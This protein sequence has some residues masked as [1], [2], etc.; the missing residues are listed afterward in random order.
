MRAFFFGPLA[1]H[2]SF[3]WHPP[4]PQFKLTSKVDIG[5]FSMQNDASSQ[6]VARGRF[7]MNAPFFC[8]SRSLYI[9]LIPAGL[10]S[11]LAFSASAQEIPSTQPFARLE[12]G[13]HTARVPRIAVDPKGR[14][15]VSASYDK[16]ARVWDLA[17][18]NLLRILRPP[19]GED[20]EG[21]LYT[22]AL[23]PDGATVAVGGF[24]SK[25]GSQT[26]PVYLFDRE[27]GR[28]T[29]RISGLPGR[30]ID[31]AFSRDG[32]F[33]AAVQKGANGI[34][35]FRV[36]DRTEVWRDSKYGDDSYSVEFDRRGRLVVVSYDGELR[37]YGPA[38]AFKMLAKKSAPGGKRPFSASFSPDGSLVAVGFDDSTA[39]NVLSGKDL[40]F[41]YS[42][43]ASQVDYGNISSIAWS[44]DGTRLYAAGSY[45]QSGIHPIVAW[46]QAGRGAAQF[47]AAATSTIHDLASLS[48]GRVALGA[49]GPA[50]AVLDA[51]GRRLVGG[52]A[53]I[54]DHRDNQRKFRLAN[55]GTMVEFGFDVWID[56][57]WLQRLARFDLR[58]RQ[59]ALDVSPAPGLTSPS[60]EGLDV[61]D[62]DN[63]SR[64]TLAG[65]PLLLQPYEISRSIAIAADRSRFA[66]GT[67]WYLRLFDRNGK[68]LWKKSIPED[69]WGVNLSSDGRFAVVALG[70]GTIRWYDGRDNGKERLAL[71]AHPDGRRWILWTPEGFFDASAGAESL[72]GYHLNQGADREGQFVDSSQ[73]AS[74][75]FR[76]D[77]ITRRLAGE[78]TAI[79]EAVKR[80][81][82]VNTV[83]AGG[84]PPRIELISPASADTDSEY[85]LTV[86]I[87]PQNGG[88]GPLKLFVNGAEVTSRSPA[89][90][91]G[92][93]VTQRLTLAPGKHEV[94]VV[95]MTRD[96]KVGSNEVTA[97]VN[98]K[99]SE[100]K[101]ALRVLAV[102]IGQYDDASFK[103]GVKFAARDA[104]ELVQRMRRGTGGVYHEVDAVVLNRRENT[105]LTRIDSEIKALVSRARPEDVV[106]I[107]LAGHGK[108]VEGEYHFIPA[109]FIYDNDR[110]YSQGRTLSHQKLEAMLAN[111]GAGK[112]LLI[113]D[114]CGSGAAIA[115]RPGGEEKDAI[116]RLMRSSGRYILAAASPQGKA[117]EDGAQGHGIY[118]YALMEGLAG[119]ADPKNTGR[120]EVDDLAKYLADRV[121]QL[122]ARFGYQ[123]R[124]MRS[125]A[126]EGFWLPRTPSTP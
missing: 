53:P 94:R 78:E 73:L 56:G 121:P 72:I 39:V 124:P 38:P 71:F 89:P 42:P 36:A 20:D 91:G 100:A 88:V 98:V 48:D 107:F 108:A 50:W 14:F 93:T 105:S 111:L 126:G 5:Y 62:W 125:A 84:L 37:L 30:T 65:K 49:S 101:P 57:K 43:D 34:G 102:G 97:I 119:A 66:L 2:L 40:R 90:P 29:G 83:L 123:Q 104:D 80:I 13:M 47:W 33:L 58:E 17:S 28:L 31:V 60:T 44:S 114:T 12:A 95:A 110:A 23:S 59:L 41:L 109:D 68:E 4:S 87:T 85:E 10:A 19:V 25:E 27:S 113:L 117:L 120:I 118:T 67:S 96:G 81:G 21:M 75:F 55:D 3:A 103:D 92:G 9:A 15:L 1:V 11:A 6:P 52:S 24:T 74:V 77:L 64:P 79:A 70:D 45:N 35:V 61:H 22:V 46:S 86:R 76:P 51:Q 99:Y 69:A 115:A 32:Q 106:I 54:L 8:R 16:T 63:N 7:D 82:D 18:G 116:S 112:R 26:Y 122:T